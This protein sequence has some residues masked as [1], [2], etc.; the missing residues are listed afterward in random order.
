MRRLVLAWM[1]ALVSFLAQAAVYTWSQYH[2]NFE[3][4]DGGFVTYNSNTRFEIQWDEMVDDMIKSFA[5]NNKNQPNREKHRQKVQTREKAKLEEQ[6]RQQEKQR[7]QQ[8]QQR[9]RNEKL[10]DA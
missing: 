5:E 7:Q 8:E 3:V 6:K 4:P 9:R 10:Y 2:L 1:L